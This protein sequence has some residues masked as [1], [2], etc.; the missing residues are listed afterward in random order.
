MRINRW[1]CTL[2]GTV[3]L[4][5][6]SALLLVPAIAPPQVFADGPDSEYFS[7]RTVVLDG[8]SIDEIIINGPPTPPPGFELVTVTLPEPN[9]AAGLN[10]LA[11]VPA[12]SWCF[13]CSATSAAMIAGY[14][15][16]TGFG[17]MYAGPTNSGVM[18][19]DNSSW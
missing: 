3:F 2:A 8:R 1:I 19:L 6:V 4:V 16:R 12:F 17:N 14:Y 18:P 10:V 9:I 7:V 15:D 5:S 11:N 13:G